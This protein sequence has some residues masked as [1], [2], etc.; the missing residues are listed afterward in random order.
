MDFLKRCLLTHSQR[1][2]T[3]GVCNITLTDAKANTFKVIMLREAFWV[4][5]LTTK[6]IKQF[7]GHVISLPLPLNG[8]AVATWRSLFAVFPPSRVSQRKLWVNWP[9]SWRR[10]DHH[11]LK[12]NFFC[13]LILFLCQ[14]CGLL[15]LCWSHAVNFFCADS[16][17]GR[18]IHHQ[19]GGQGRHLL[20]HQQGQ[21]GVQQPQQ[22]ASHSSECGIDHLVITTPV[23]W[24][25][26]RRTQSVRRRRT[27]ESSPG[28][29]GLEKGHYRGEVMWLLYISVAS[30]HN[31]TKFSCRRLKQWIVNSN[32]S[33]GLK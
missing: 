30:R 28:A 10:W 26:P 7:R 3:S 24:M 18:R 23:R 9:T 14:D 27:S 12:H 6:K 1:G 5:M 32:S 17:W 16:L 33:S 22:H 31:Q 8:P 25:W 4:S 20:H 13:L 11:L 29:T 15:I 21:G 2:D 19:A